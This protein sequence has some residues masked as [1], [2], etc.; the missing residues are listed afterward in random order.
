VRGRGDISVD[1]FDWHGEHTD[2]IARINA[3]VRDNYE[4]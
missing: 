3:I 1:G 4:F 2:M